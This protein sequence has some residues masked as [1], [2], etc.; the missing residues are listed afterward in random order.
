M[1]SDSEFG[2]SSA[3]S[4]INDDDLVSE[5]PTEDDTSHSESSEIENLPPN[6]RDDIAAHPEND[7][8]SK[9]KT[10]Q[11]S[12]IPIDIN[13]RLSYRQNI[14]NVIS[15]NYFKIHML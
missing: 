12:P 15:G 10:I 11:Y 7:W 5:V 1:D 6:I 9:D 13:D 2:D 14:T 8:L 3:D 4:E